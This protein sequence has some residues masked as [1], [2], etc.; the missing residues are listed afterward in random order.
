MN[1]TRTHTW[2][3]IQ[4]R[5]RSNIANGKWLP[6]D[7]IPGEVDLAKEFGCSRTTVNRA[8]RELASTGVIDR[9]RK[10]GTRVAVLPAL[11][12]RATIPIIRSQIE[13]QECSY[14]YTLLKKRLVKPEQSIQAILRLTTSCKALHIQSLHLADAKPY[15]Y[16]DR[17]IN[18][19]SLPDVFE[20]DFSKTSANEWLVQHVPFTNGNFSVEAVNANQRVA[21]LLGVEPGTAIL[22]SRRTTWLDDHSVTTVK[23]SYRSDHQMMFEI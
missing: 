14:G 22:T 16:E 17:W 5:I 8:M 9:K 12:I 18:P 23:S 4:A 20:V 2:Q 13:S 15:L 21:K 1:N 7:L 6:G 19:H 10:S 11:Q 3:D